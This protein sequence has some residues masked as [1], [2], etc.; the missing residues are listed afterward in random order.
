MKRF[1]QAIIQMESYIMDAI[2]HIFK[3]S[4][5]PGMPFFESVTK[6]SPIMMD[7]LFKRADKY[8]MLEDDIQATS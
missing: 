8:S 1:N 4:I 5:N 2:L 3:R 6:K 7:N